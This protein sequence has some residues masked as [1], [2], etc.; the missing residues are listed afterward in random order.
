M[1]LK[2]N[3]KRLSSYGLPDPEENE[4]ELQRAILEIDINQQ[5]QLLQK[6]NL[7]TPNTQQ[8]QDIFD[9]IMYSILNKRTKLYFIQGKGGSGKTTLAKKFL[10][11]PELK[12]LYV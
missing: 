4:T 3:D 11:L 5:T 8:Q 1:K 2:D 6:L 10:Q 12:T 9:Q 7:D